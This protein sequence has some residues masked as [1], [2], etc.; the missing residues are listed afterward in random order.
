M[1]NHGYIY[2]TPVVSAWYPQG[3]WRPTTWNTLC[4]K[5]LP[6]SLAVNA[7]GW[8][9]SL[10]WYNATQINVDSCSWLSTWPRCLIL[11]VI[12][13]SQTICMQW[14]WYWSFSTPSKIVFPVLGAAMCMM[15][16]DG[17]AQQPGLQYH[18]MCLAT[19]PRHQ[20]PLMSPWQPGWD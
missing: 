14:G 18:S 5:H 7:M 3:S 6:N 4:D 9:S 1:T 15:T 19:S 8:T 2:T 10:G 13:R 20:R 17:I 11:L 12:F 16:G